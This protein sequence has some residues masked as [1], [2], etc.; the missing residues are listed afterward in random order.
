ML[1]TNCGK[2]FKSISNKTS[3]CDDCIDE[4]DPFMYD[5]ESDSDVDVV[6]LKQRSSRT[7]P[8]YV[9]EDFEQ[10]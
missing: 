6:F 8:F 7:Q 5:K 1:C 9:D 4:Q 2:L 3:I 10:D